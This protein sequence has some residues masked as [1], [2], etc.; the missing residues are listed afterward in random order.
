MLDASCRM[1]QLCGLLFLF[2]HKLMYM[3][4]QFHTV[5][6]A[7]VCREWEEKMSELVKSGVIAQWLPLHLL[8][9]FVLNNKCKSGLLEWTCSLFAI[10]SCFTLETAVL[11]YP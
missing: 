4:Q 5:T 11:I 1:I 7:H 10:S 2:F 9:S 6:I 3:C 8:L